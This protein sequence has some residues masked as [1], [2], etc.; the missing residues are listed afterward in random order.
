ML[1]YLL[2]GSFEVHEV[3]RETVEINREITK[4]EK[5]G[6]DDDHYDS[7]GN[8]VDYQKESEEKD[9]CETSTGV[10]NGE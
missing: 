4:V 10:E 3:E 7:S 2:C 8:D 6:G 5:E 9:F 1:P